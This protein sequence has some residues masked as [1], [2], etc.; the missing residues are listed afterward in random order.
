MEPIWSPYGTRNEIRYGTRYEIRM[1]LDM[2]L[3]TEITTITPIT[4]RNKKLHHT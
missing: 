4:N 2:K 3:G 1:Q